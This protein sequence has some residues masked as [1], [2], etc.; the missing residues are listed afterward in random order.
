MSGVNYKDIIPDQFNLGPRTWDV[1]YV[2]CSHFRLDGDYGCC[3][4]ET[5]TIYL[6]D[7][8]EP[9]MMVVAFGHEYNHAEDF[10]RGL[11]E[12]DEVDIDA[13]GQ[14]FAQFLLTQKHL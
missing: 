12:H 13:R 2:P 1:Q 14:L 6:N 4:Y 5:A 7:S 10:T 3:D 8:L 11:T 9:T